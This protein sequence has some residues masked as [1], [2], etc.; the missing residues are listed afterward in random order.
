[1]A[2]NK[3]IGK[4]NKTIETKKH[5]TKQLD[6]KTQH[7]TLKQFVLGMCYELTQ[8][9][10][11]GIKYMLWSRN[12]FFALN[13]QNIALNQNSHTTNFSNYIIKNANTKS[14]L[15]TVKA[16]TETVKVNMVLVIGNKQL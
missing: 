4:K 2:Q 6:Q 16:E 1:M 11:V 13:V 5:N 8:M 9:T 15:I 3:T 7:K 10:A 14:G 12:S